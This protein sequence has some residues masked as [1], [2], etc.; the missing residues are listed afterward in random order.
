MTIVAHKRPGHWNVARHDT[1]IT[2]LGSLQPR[3]K[4]NCCTQFSGGSSGGKV[5]LTVG[6]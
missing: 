3:A 2:K 6:S 5:Y 1:N 4:Q